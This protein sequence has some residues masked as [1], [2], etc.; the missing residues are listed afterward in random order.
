MATTGRN[1]PR[2]A[3]PS[4]EGRPAHACSSTSAEDYRLLAETASDV[5]FRAGNDAVIQWIS[6]SV[7]DLLGWDPEQIVGRP[8]TDIIHPEDMTRFAAARDK[9]L[10]GDVVEFE[11]RLRDAGGTYH[12]I[13]SK[14]R[15]LLDAAGAVVGRAGGWRDVD[16]AV[17]AR[18]A[19]AASEELFRLALQNAAVGMC[20]VSPDG[21]FLRVNPALCQMLGRDE[22]ALL[23]ATWQE[24]THPDD[25]DVD[26]EQV[27]D[28]LSARIPSY[29]R[30]KRFLRPDGSFLWGDLSVSAVH[31][32]DGSVRHLVSQVADVSAEVAAE[33]AVRRRE[34]QMQAVAD[35][36]ADAI[37]TAD[38]T[39]TITDWN[40]AAGL[41]FGY[42]RSEAIGQPLT[43]LMPSRYAVIHPAAMERFSSSR[44]PRVMG[45]AVEVVGRRRDGGEFPLEVCLAEWGIEDERFV[46]ATIRDLTERKQAQAALHESEE[47][48]AN[49]V[50]GS[51]VGLWDWRIQTGETSYNERW[52]ATCGYTLAELAP[53][54]IETWIALC[55]PDDRERSGLLLEEHFAGRTPRYECETRMRHKDGHWVWVLDRGTVVERDADG[56][57]SRMTGT[58]LDISDR[59]RAE[60]ALRESEE[61]LSGTLDSL[62]DPHLVLQAERD[63]QGAVR[64]FRLAYANTAASQVMQRD[65]EQLREMSAL[66][67]L[68]AAIESGVFQLLVSA[69][70]AGTPVVIDDFAFRDKLL[71]QTSYF[72][73]RATRIGARLSVT[74]R[75]VTKRHAAEQAI[76]R[77]MAELD[78]LQ[79]LSELLVTRAD[80][81]TALDEARGLLAE[82]FAA[83]AGEVRLSI[84]DLDGV[85]ASDPALVALGDGCPPTD[86]EGEGGRHLL[87]VPLTA[88]DETFG[89]LVVQR[90]LAAGPFDSA[91]QA[92]A[93]TA[94]DLLAAV[95]RNERLHAM[96]T[97]QATAL[98]RQRIAR[99][100]H[101]AVTQSIYSASLIADALPALWERD[102][103]EGRC[104][105]LVIRRLIRAALAELRILLFELRPEALAAAPLEG[106][107]QRLGDALAGQAEIDIAVAV[108]EG[109]DLPADVRLAFY[110]VAQEALNNVG[111]Y[112]EAAHV[113]VTLTAD[114]DGEVSLQ[115]AD[116][117][118]GFDLAAV[119]PGSLG[120]G[121]MQ[122]RAEAAGAC[123]TVQSAPHAG[124]RVTMVWRRPA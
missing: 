53:L 124:T 7:R 57:P 47:R 46:T 29:R 90:D 27:D 87:A 94:A 80:L 42:S 82:L 103:D 33:A 73:V 101:D 115:V 8:T 23:T 108:D 38:M 107:L 5:V 72:D 91:E 16:E 15:P 10:H 4:A 102:P 30:R 55:H 24:L 59:V 92:L 52:A 116:D 106:L 65:R 64:D 85:A 28:V 60:E 111:K 123:L 61:L 70:E 58:H 75:D 119:R 26:L 76:R 56:R 54:S 32:D 98:E 89:A 99:D 117:G 35:S 2:A 11:M 122:E 22:T 20:L 78:A 17:R 45:R 1:N 51:G 40:R 104:D 44:E 36:A 19:L 86:A 118:Q 113:A 79:R 14:T 97:Q 34:A 110:R 66:A 88:H 71:D 12:W 96:E 93:R 25:L 77:R 105:L 67:S 95:V 62:M 83:R 74:W 49:A 50:E 109:L 63:E 100:L 13:S 112:A 3:G 31:N 18:Q 114:R 9:V 37:I 48:L 81:S 21:R 68:P 43:V 39:G 41:M 120:L 6:P 84:A 69:F 121:I